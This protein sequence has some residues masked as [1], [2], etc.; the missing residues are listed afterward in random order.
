MCK[1]LWS[2]I[3]KPK[4]YPTEINNFEILKN[5]MRLHNEY[6]VIVRKMFIENLKFYV[7]RFLPANSA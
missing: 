7:L 4:I 3:F 1:Y 2:I 6:L 5:E